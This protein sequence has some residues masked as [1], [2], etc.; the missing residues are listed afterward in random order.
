MME[1]IFNFI[2][3]S[4]NKTQFVQKKIELSKKFLIF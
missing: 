4:L 1:S 3:K 2:R